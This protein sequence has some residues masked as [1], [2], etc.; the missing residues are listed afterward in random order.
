MRHI[1]VC[2]GMLWLSVASLAMGADNPSPDE[3]AIRAAVD[4]YVAAYNRGDAKAVADHW[5]ETAEWVSPAG[6]KIQGR[7][8]IEQ[9]LTAMFV[10]LK[11][12]KVEVSSPT[13]RLV[14]ADVAIEE[15]TVTVVRPGEAP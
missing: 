2:F 7:A 3:A 12:L 5:S 1:V 11:G 8:A 10:E 6:K 9:A 13:V 15:G 4:S 14:T